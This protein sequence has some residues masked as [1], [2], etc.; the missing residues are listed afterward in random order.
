VCVCAQA[1]PE[2]LSTATG[3][4]LSCLPPKLSYKPRLGT[5]N[6][7]NLS[8]GTVKSHHAT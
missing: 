3:P 4:Q 1:P 8:L 6:V 5:S 2:P 7:Q